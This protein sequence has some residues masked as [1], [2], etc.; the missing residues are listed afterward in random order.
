MTGWFGLGA[1]LNH[2]KTTK[3]EAFEQMK[4][5]AEQ[6]PF[7]KYMMIQLETNLLT[8]NPDI[9]L[10]FKNLM[11]DQSIAEELTG[12]I[13][14]DFNLAI[15]LTDEILGGDRDG[16]RFAKKHDSELRNKGLAPLH[17]IQLEEI[18][19]WRAQDNHEEP[20]EQLLHKQLLVVNAL[21]GG[22][23]STG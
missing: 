7:F 19:K 12:L 15:S 6:W 16:R 11:D 14:E 17:K 2:I 18:K 20:R 8:V 5:W 13:M 10:E 21:A 22:L 23:K 1:G 3:P 9:I 4:T